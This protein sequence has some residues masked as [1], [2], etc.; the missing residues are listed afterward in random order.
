VRHILGEHQ[1]LVEIDI[2]VRQIDSENG[3]VVADARAQQQRLLAVEQHL[4]VRQMP[5]VAKENAVRPPGRRPDVGKTVEYGEAI[6][7]FEGAAGPGGGAGRRNI[8]GGFWNLLDQR[9]G[10]VLSKQWITSG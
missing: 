8:E 10:R 3:V 6:T 2:G 1:L 4:K 7:V 5:R 9:R